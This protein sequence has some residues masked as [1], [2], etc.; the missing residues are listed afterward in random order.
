METP[1]TKTDEPK[2]IQ[3]TLPRLDKTH[4]TPLSILVAA[5]IISGSIIVSGGSPKS[6]TKTGTNALQPPASSQPQI[7][8]AT[9][10]N[11]DPLSKTDHLRGNRNAPVLLIEY[12]DL[13]CPFCK[14][15]HPTAKQTVDSYGGKVAWVYRHFPIEQLHS[16]APKESEA[17]ECAAEIGGEDGFWKFIDKVYEVTPS[18]N[19]LDP[20]ELPKIAAQVGLDSG[21]FKSCLDA[22]QMAA[23]VQSQYQSGT[24]AGIT[25]TPGNI[26]LNTKTGKTKLIPGAVPY[27]SLKTDIDNLLSGS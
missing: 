25:G 18:N 24:K 7:A 8:G 4:L 15:F 20:A 12:S 17:A 6:S 1:Q 14:R 21:K 11:V 19:G 26:L 9:A 10:Q 2:T 13:E 23:K 16:K 22:G 3:I 27:D 5:L